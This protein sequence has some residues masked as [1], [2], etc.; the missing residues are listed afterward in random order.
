MG[1]RSCTLKAPSCRGREGTITGGGMASAAFL[2]LSVRLSGRLGTTTGR[3]TP[4]ACLL[5]ALEGAA[6]SA[7]CFAVPSALVVIGLAEV[8][9]LR[10]LERLA[11]LDSAANDEDCEEARVERV[12]SEDDGR[13]GGFGGALLAGL[14]PAAKYFFM[15]GVRGATNLESY[16]AGTDQNRQHAH[17]LTRFGN[18]I[19]YASNI[20]LPTLRISAFASLAVDLIK[21]SISC[22]RASFCKSGGLNLSRQA[23]ALS[24]TARRRE[25]DLSF[26]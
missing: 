3:S 15:V 14:V 8:G 19:E 11:D 13:E 23:S 1:A 25:V 9:T 12:D 26:E 16:E 7:P 6:T 20:F 24:A 10:V 22:P 5:G 4:P 21:A 2:V 18:S 17:R